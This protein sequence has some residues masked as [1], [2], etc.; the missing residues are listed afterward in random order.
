V[1]PFPQLSWTLANKG[2]EEAFGSLVVVFWRAHLGELVQ[3]YENIVMLVMCGNRA[4]REDSDAFAQKGEVAGFGGSG[5]DEQF[6][7]V[8]SWVGLGRFVLQS[9]EKSELEVE[10]GCT[11]HAARRKVPSHQKG[12][13]ASRL[14]NSC[15][16][17]QRPKSAC[18]FPS[19]P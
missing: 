5:G 17:K 6:R 15:T 7:C 18:L 2:K 13:S 16:R 10:P 3:D 4:L 11:E 14:E 12:V 19:S 8:K 9:Y 1:T